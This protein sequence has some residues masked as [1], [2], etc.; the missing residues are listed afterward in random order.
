MKILI[1]PR[2][3]E[4]MS[5]DFTT[6]WLMY[7]GLDSTYCIVTKG[8]DEESSSESGNKQPP[9]KVALGDN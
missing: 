7:N 8:K 5:I 3:F 6:K 1:V 2:K 4:R 9:N